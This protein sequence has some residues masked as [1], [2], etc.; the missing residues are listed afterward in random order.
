MQKNT[1]NGLRKT[2]S[3]ALVLASLVLFMFSI[4]FIVIARNVSSIKSALGGGL[5]GVS[6]LDRETFRRSYPDV[7]LLSSLEVRFPPGPPPLVP[8]STFETSLKKKYPV[9]NFDDMGLKFELL[10]AIGVAGRITD[11]AYI[12]SFFNANREFASAIEYFYGRPFADNSSETVIINLPGAAGD[13]QKRWMSV[14][15]NILT[16]SK[17]AERALLKKDHA[18]ALKADLAFLRMSDPDGSVG[19]P[20]ISNIVDYGLYN[21]YPLSLDIF[22]NENSFLTGG[23]DLAAMFEEA[24]AKRVEFIKKRPN[25]AVAIKNSV[26]LVKSAAENLSWKEK[27]TYKALNLWYGDPNVPFFEA[28]EK[29][30]AIRNS[31]YSQ[32]EKALAAVHEK[33]PRKR[34]FSHELAY[35]GDDLLSLIKFIKYAVSTHPLPPASLVPVHGLRQYIYIETRLRMVTLGGLARLFYAS[36]KRWPDPSKDPEFFEKAGPAA[37]D[38]YTGGPYKLTASAGGDKLIIASAVEEWKDP[39]KKTPGTVTLYAGRPF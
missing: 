28:A 29:L 14:Y 17:F 36:N 10:S 24:L 35:T 4:I 38:M 18:M 33:Y 6:R 34:S 7:F 27:V 20:N 32:I 31:P 12:D 21:E 19:A 5:D 3:N 2:L 23:A 1:K 8:G 25:F 13:F 37:I 22:I 11:E 26:S 15:L 30:Y 16:A 39:S 9:M